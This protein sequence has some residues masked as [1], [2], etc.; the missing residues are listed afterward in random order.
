MMPDW[1]VLGA[2][3]V[4]EAVSVLLSIGFW[5]SLD[6]SF[7]A[8]AIIMTL[9]LWFLLKSLLVSVAALLFH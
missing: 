9:V 7:S 1:L 4:A 3:Y 8:W 5:I 2:R 6:N